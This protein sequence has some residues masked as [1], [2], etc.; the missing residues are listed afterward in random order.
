MRPWYGPDF[1]RRPVARWAVITVFS[2]VA[3]LAP[4]SLV[5]EA[6]AATSPSILRQMQ[7]AAATSTKEGSADFAMTEGVSEPGHGGLEMIAARGVIDFSPAAEDLAMSLPFVGTSTSIDMIEVGSTVY[8][9]SPKGMAGLQA[10]KWYSESAQQAGSS[11]GIQVGP[12]GV[13]GGNPAEFLSLL[14]AEGASVKRVGTAVTGGAPTTEYAVDVN[15]EKALAHAKGSGGA[16]ATPQ[17]LQFLHTLFGS[18]QLPMTV[19]ID[20]HSLVR[21]LDMSIHLDAG[22]LAG[23][24]ATGGAAGSLT[25]SLDLTHYGHRIQ[26]RPPTS[27]TPAPTNVL[28]AQ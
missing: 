5:G 11:A 13:G 16:T 28:P 25:I 14:A 18:N 12:S 7:R 27:S 10:G 2:V 3:L 1:R 24:G 22:A 23:L 4:I 19:W 9:R 8:L 21:R 6:G 15:L 17:G 20:H 26:I